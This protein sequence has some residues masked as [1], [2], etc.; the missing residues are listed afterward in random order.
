M[1]SQQIGQHSV[2]EFHYVLS[3]MDGT[4]LDNSRERNAP[5]SYLHGAANLVRGLEQAMVDHV[6]G[7]RFRVEVPPELGYG[8]RRGGPQPVPRSIFPADTDLAPGGSFTTETPEGNQM[9]LWITRIEGDQV[10]VDPHHPLAGQTLRYAV[11]VL[12]VREATLA[13]INQ[14]R[15]V[16][17]RID[18]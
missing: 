9:M 5:M 6:V 4:V 14:G 18:A 8:V 17:S 3:D 12:Q 2:V 16:S 15:P 10:W 11:E 7:D 1:E 13:E